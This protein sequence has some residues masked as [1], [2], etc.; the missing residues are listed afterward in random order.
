AQYVACVQGLTERPGSFS[1]AAFDEA[2]SLEAIV[3]AKSG[4][5]ITAYHI[6]KLTDAC[7]SGRHTQA[8][9]HA[10]AAAPTL[11]DVMATSL[12]ATF[13]FHHALT[14]AALQRE[15]AGDPE[16]E[17]DRTLKRHLG[18]L[19]HWAQHCPENF[20]SRHSLVAAEVARNEGRVLQAIELY[21]EAIRSA[22]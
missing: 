18:K 15:G 12:E 10:L 13:C 9:Q 4:A 19:E 2:K 7:V 5:S 6:M 3:T 22:R 21:E 8:Q 11:R 14:L 16:R 20:Q 17:L 1:D